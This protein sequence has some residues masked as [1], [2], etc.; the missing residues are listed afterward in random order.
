MH[1]VGKPDL[2]TASAVE[3]EIAVALGGDRVDPIVRRWARHGSFLPALWSAL[4]PNV[5][6][7][8]FRDATDHLRDEALRL[9]RAVGEVDA[10]RRTDMNQEQRK[11]LADGLEAWLAFDARLLTFLVMGHTLIDGRPVGIGDGVGGERVDPPEPLRVPGEDVDA[12]PEL[13]P[14]LRDIQAAHALPE[15]RPEYRLVASVPAYARVA[16]DELLR[17]SRMAGHGE[18]ARRLRWTAGEASLRMPYRVEPLPDS[19]YGDARAELQRYTWDMDLAFGPLLLNVAYLV[20]DW[21][22]ANRR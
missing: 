22:K 17:V 9:A 3:R 4:K 20:I 14:L 7:A 16:W 5:E 13:E 8:A 11:L 15:R 21:R 19:V 18:N 1:P 2:E 10:A 6:S 12:D